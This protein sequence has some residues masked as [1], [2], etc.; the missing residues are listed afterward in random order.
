METVNI[1]AAKTNLSRLIER[2]E[3]G[4]EIVISRNGKPV[5]KLG[6][7]QTEPVIDKPRQFGQWEGQVWFAP[8]Y[9]EAD[10]MIEKMFED[11]LEKDWKE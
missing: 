9:D 1:H 8:D 4:E 7:I 11:E 6:A 10:A 2:V 5:A 3:K